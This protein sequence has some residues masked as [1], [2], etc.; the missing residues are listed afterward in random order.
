M[1][2]LQ[3]VAKVFVRT[4]FLL[5]LRNQPIH[6][7]ISKYVLISRSRI[8][9][10]KKVPQ[11]LNHA[12]PFRWVYFFHLPLYI[13]SN[14]AFAHILLQHILN[15]HVN[16]NVYI[17]RAL[18]ISTYYIIYAYSSCQVFPWKTSFLVSLHTLVQRRS[19]AAVPNY[20][21]LWFLNHCRCAT[22]DNAGL[23]AAV[24]EPLLISIISSGS[25]T[26]TE[27]SC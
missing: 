19:S 24:L 27:N 15:L 11:I 20:H 10:D 12:Y 23:S 13:L 22:A 2:L 14:H 3:L 21:Q 9:V 8:P 5:V 4:H 1:G 7:I 6:T 18:H 25:R 26:S 17:R 16:I